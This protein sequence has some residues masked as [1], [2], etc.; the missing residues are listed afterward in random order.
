MFELG[1]VG[2]VLANEMGEE[3]WDVEVFHAYDHYS[4]TKKS[5]ILIYK[6]PTKNCA[7]G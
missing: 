4:R 3:I 6:T 7:K 5:P 1:T 2:S